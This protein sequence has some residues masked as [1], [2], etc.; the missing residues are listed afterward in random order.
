M[1]SRD[2]RPD[3]IESL[4]GDPQNLPEIARLMGQFESEEAYAKFKRPNGK[5]LNHLPALWHSLANTS[6]RLTRVRF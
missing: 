3:K 1:A 5:R 2:V 4:L 6:D